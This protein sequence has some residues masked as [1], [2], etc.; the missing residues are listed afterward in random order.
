M[1]G[2]AFDVD[3]RVRNK[4]LLGLTDLEETLRYVGDI[5]ALRTDD[6]S[7]RP[8]LYELPGRGDAP[9]DAPNASG[10]GDRSGRPG[11]GPRNTEP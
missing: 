4:L 6:R 10:E 8:W 1:E 3:P 7:R 5:T 9:A 2:I 11:S